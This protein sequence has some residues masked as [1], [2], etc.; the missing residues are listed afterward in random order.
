MLAAG[1]KLGPYEI[2][3]PLGA[4]GMGEVYRARD[5][6]LGRDVAIK[7]LPQHLSADPDLRA[8]LEREARAISSLNH[9][10]ICVLHDVG[11]QDGVDFLVM[12]HLEGETLAARLE[13][14]PLAT[15]PL[16][17]TAIEIADALDKAH[18]SGLAHRDLKPGNIMVTK[19][20]AKLMDFGL[21]RATGMAGGPTGPAL[22]QTPTMT[23]PLTAE[24]SIVGTF[25][26][27]APEQLEG[28][29]ADTRTDLFAF[30]AVLYEMATG[31]KA[32]EGKSQAS[33]ISAIMSSEPPPI[34]T[35]APLT[36][37]ALERVVK[38]CLAKDPDNRWQSAAD[39]K[40]ELQWIRDAGSQA[41]VAA[42]VAARR[43][44]RERL[45]WMTALA[46]VVVAAAGVALAPR[47]LPRNQAGRVVRFS[48]APPEDLSF[49][50][51]SGA[52]ANSVISP[53]GRVLVFAPIDSTGTTR[54]WVRPMES[55][56]AR[57][58]PGTEGAF[59]PFW[60][61]DG[62]SIG[63]FA[64][65]KLK[66]VPVDG[67]RPQ[68]LCDASDGRGGTW[69][70]LG[71]ILF[72]PSAQAPL[73][74]VPASGGDVAQV[75]TLDTTRKEIA[76]RW[77]R[78]L[79]D[80]RHFLYLSLPE[81]GG[82][83]DNFI[84]SLDGKPG[85]L[86]ARSDRAAVYAPPGYLLLVRNETLL[87]QKFDAAR[88]ASRGEPVSLGELPDAGGNLGEP[89]ASVS[90]DGVLVSQSV[91]P[92]ETRLAWLDRTGKEVGTVP[93]TPG[94]YGSMSLPS[95]DGRRAVLLRSD[96]QT[97]TDLWLVDLDR[98]TTTRFTSETGNEF[99][100]AWS[101]DGSRLA[102]AS[103]RSGPYNIYARPVTGSGQEEVLFQSSQLKKWPVAWSPDGR[104]IVFVGGDPKSGDDLWILP[105]EGDRKPVPYLATRFNESS[106]S[107]S[108]DGRWLAYTS[109]ETG[110]NEV[111][112]QPFPEPGAKSQVSTGGASAAGGSAAVWSR[113]GRELYFVTSDGKAM[114][115]DIQTKPDFRASVPRLLF[116]PPHDFV[117]F[118]FSGG[119]G[120][121]LVPVGAQRPTTLTVVMN[122]AA[123][124]KDK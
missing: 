60:S 48:I 77:P 87:A 65:G 98:G 93:M 67:G 16:L 41:G 90:D 56:G 78:F 32:F 36:P 96:P 37:P 103:N 109:D 57:E 104:S 84:G 20:G 30:G 44:S 35:V 9:P 81:R 66:R 43:K 6:R 120:L 102:F 8:R 94:P 111:Y 58:L 26:Y 54:L 13:R 28:Q 50:R 42:P 115:S 45:A 1:T 4:G 24:G 23:Q 52:P 46:V 62:R 17:T 7:V 64:D 106:G 47:L 124:L 92:V 38:Q 18:R 105:L 121:C 80:G 100:M 31:K 29:E 69:S 101:P 95:P 114:V 39:L 5:T 89:N 34:S 74:R 14:G 122:W 99:A 3:G 110:R 61:P 108:P 19:S 72:S 21:A 86:V 79:P 49:S 107:I 75:T 117:D 53:N 12:E 10:H 27:M 82:Q 59:Y 76:H 113:D 112:V 123:G 11:H 63:F 88:G 70:R 40:R 85:R 33:L 55:L 83:F 22:S 15:G 2:T 51:G 71:M 68:V 97:A 91:V 118:N 25:Q 116:R 73:F 119:R